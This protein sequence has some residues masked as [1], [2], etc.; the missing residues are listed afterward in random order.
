MQQMS[1]FIIILHPK[2]IN[3]FKRGFLQSIQL[4]NLIDQFVFYEL[5]Y[6]SPLLYKFL[7]FYV[8]KNITLFSNNMF[9]ILIRLVLV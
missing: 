4:I 7:L 3:T 1:I 2:E 6:L 5:I 8:T 9:V